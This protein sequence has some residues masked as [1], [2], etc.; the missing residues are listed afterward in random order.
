MARETDFMKFL[1]KIEQTNAIDAEPT[2]SCP[3]CKVPLMISA[4]CTCPLC[5][6]CFNYQ[7]D[8]G[9]DPMAGTIRL[10]ITKGKSKRVGVN[11]NYTDTQSKAI[12]E[13][14][15]K[16]KR[17][18]DNNNG[19][20][21]P[22]N[23][24]TEAAIKYNELQQIVVDGKKFVKRAAVKKQIL[25]ALIKIICDNN[26]VPRKEQDIARFMEL[27]TDGFSQGNIIVREYVTA[28]LLNLNLEEN[29]LRDA[30]AFAERYLE[31]LGMPPEFI[32]RGADFV[33]DCIEISINNR[34]AYASKIT[35]KVAGLIWI[36]N[37]RLNLK[38]TI[39][40]IEKAVDGTKKSTYS[41]FITTIYKRHD[42]FS[43]V[44]VKYDIPYV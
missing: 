6:R 9:T 36:I 2:N 16:R 32:A 26:N 44:F 33:R 11:S 13:L 18:N 25:C 15:L 31:S 34:I 28:G 38:K 19:I 43:D 14:L 22:Q 29:P 1:E 7:A 3:D 4:E 35:S 37:D 40:Q 20:I 5:G 17:I 27:E 24:L 23:I 8:G 10:T 21:I 12:E 41:A 39:P 42:L 30:K